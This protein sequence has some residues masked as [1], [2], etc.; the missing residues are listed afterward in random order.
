MLFFRLCNDSIYLHPEDKK[1]EFNQVKF[2]ATKVHSQ[3]SSTLNTKKEE[4]L[5]SNEKEASNSQ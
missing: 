2:H 4:E 1:I 3:I 5:R